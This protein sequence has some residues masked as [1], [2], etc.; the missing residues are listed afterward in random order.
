MIA[1]LKEG[2]AGMRDFE[3]IQCVVIPKNMKH[4]ANIPKNMI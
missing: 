3:A 4:L 2:G 1:P